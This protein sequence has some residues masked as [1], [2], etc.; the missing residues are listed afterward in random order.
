MA[1][2]RAADFGYRS[3]ARMRSIDDLDVMTAAFAERLLAD[4][5]LVAALSGSLRDMKVLRDRCLEASI[6]A[7]VGQKGCASGG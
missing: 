7:M 1:L 4:R 3:R 6:P 2:H 5:P